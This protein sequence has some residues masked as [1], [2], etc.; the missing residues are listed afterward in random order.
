MF[1]LVCFGLMFV[2]LSNSVRMGR[3]SV[4]EAGS[5]TMVMLFMLFALCGCS[6]SDATPTSATQPTVLWSASYDRG[7]LFLEVDV[8]SAAQVSELTLTFDREVGSRDMVDHCVQVTGRTSDTVSTW[9]AMVDGKRCTVQDTGATPL[10][11]GK[12]I[13][14]F[15]FRLHRDM[16]DAGKD[17]WTTPRVLTCD[18]K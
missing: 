12:H 14:V 1:L 6:K 11:V 13:M 4:R 3:C 10:S 16:E 7:Y 18:V 9:F 17:Y 5:L 15:E 2:Y 8:R